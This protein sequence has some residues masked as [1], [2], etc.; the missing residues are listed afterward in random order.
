MFFSD[1]ART[2]YRADHDGDDALVASNDVIFTVH[3]L[4]LSLVY[5]VQVCIYRR[6]EEGPSLC[7]VAICI[8]LSFGIVFG[9][10][11]VYWGNVSILFYIYSI[12]YIKIILTVLK[13]IPQAWLNFVRKS[14]AGYSI[15]N[16]IFDISGGIFSIS[17]LLI[18]AY[19]AGE[20]SGIFGNMTKLML[21]IISTVFDLLFL[22]QHYILYRKKTDP[23]DWSTVNQLELDKDSI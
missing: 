13:L 23:S 7:G 17:Q 8:I 10:L 19:I 22:F 12:S 3:G 2:A 16:V 11:A 5:F 14:T 4:V 18:D 9:A 6:P 21:G 20:W 1:S 15:W